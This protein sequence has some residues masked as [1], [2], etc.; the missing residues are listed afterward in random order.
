MSASILSIQKL[1]CSDDVPAYFVASTAPYNVEDPAQD[2]GTSPSGELN[3][4]TQEYIAD[5]ANQLSQQDD[6]DRPE[7]LIVVHGYNTSITGVKEWFESIQKHIAEHCQ[8]RSKKFLLI[9]Y[10][11][12][13][14]QIISS[15]LANSG[16]SKLDLIKDKYKSSRSVLPVTLRIISKYGTLGFLGSGAL[17]LVSLLARALQI[18][19]S[20]TALVIALVLTMTCLAAIAPIITILLLRLA[21]YFR[22]NYRANYYGIPD[23][24][25]LIRQIDS[26]LIQGDSDAEKE[27][28]KQ[29]WDDNRLKL[30]FI[31]HSMGGFV[32][33]NTVRILSDVFDSSSIGTLD[34]VNPEKDPSSKIGNVFCLGRLVLV[35]PDIPAETIISGRANFLKS[36]LRRFDESYLFSNEGDMALRLASTA[37][38]Y[39]SFPTRTQDGGYRLGN[40]TVRSAQPVESKG[41][42]EKS[43]DY[44][45]I[46]RLPNELLVKLQG[47]AVA[48]HPEQSFGYLLGAQ[49]AVIKDGQPVN[50]QG[51]PLN[52][53]QDGEAIG[54]QQGTLISLK[55]GQIVRIQNGPVVRLQT[56]AANGSEIWRFVEVQAGQLGRIQNDD[57][58]SLDHGQFIKLEYGR[59]AQVQDG[60]IVALEDGQ[61][62]SGSAGKMFQVLKGQLFEIQN[63]LPVE[64]DNPLPFVQDDQLVKFQAGQFVRLQEVKEGKILENPQPIEV[65]EQDKI[66]IVGRFPL[67]YLYIRQKKALSRRQGSVAL[68]PNETPIGELFTFFDC[69]DYVEPLQKKTVG[70]VSNAKRRKALNIWDYLWLTVDYFSGKIDTHGGYFGNGEVLNG[71]AVKPEAAFSKSAIYGLACLGFE[72]FLEELGEQDAFNQDK[73]LQASYTK[74]LEALDAQGSD[75]T[76]RQKRKIA[77]TQIFSEICQ[78]KQIQVLLSQ[79]CY[80]ESVLGLEEGHQP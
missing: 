72:K 4:S 48:H 13:S 52:A 39:F 56:Q 43:E 42:K 59:I 62:V 27:K 29:Y 70:I 12:P 47:K 1:D 19:G 80:E 44:G 73:D 34:A 37:A 10:R 50:L 67:D 69:T 75:F 15:D 74:L 38:N 21:G 71:K 6:H 3:K 8:N 45:L 2:F 17:L 32:V 9:G 36:S 25:E 46:V 78:K 40:V 16:I 28:S 33:T 63:G 23:L 18:P 61:F 58:F 79:K 24:V 65:S 31:G 77:A 66:A 20:V 41:G 30:S 64:L 5:I 35:S 49:L 11:W 54:P 22:D 68:A 53:L 60:A 26:G 57:L 76:D 51:K 14:E 55:A 7:I